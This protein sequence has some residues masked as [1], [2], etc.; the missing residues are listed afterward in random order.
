MQNSATSG[1]SIHAM[2][3]THA[4][5]SKLELI[6]DGCYFY[7]ST[8]S[9]V[10]G[11]I[12]ATDIGSLQIQKSQFFDCFIL[13]YSVGLAY[14]GAIHISNF[15]ELSISSSDFRSCM[16]NGGSVSSGGAVYAD[17]GTVS[18]SSITISG[19]EFY[20]SIFPYFVH[21]LF[22][23]SLSYFFINFY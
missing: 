7:S 9:I 22:L 1:G 17:E 4:D 15:D 6:V 23:F 14:G 11:A 10:G 20:V 21:T 8:A 12:C 5:Y 2:K 18:S 3:N 19:S 13:S 16:A